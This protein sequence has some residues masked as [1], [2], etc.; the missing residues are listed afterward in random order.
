MMEDFSSLFWVKEGHLLPVFPYQVVEVDHQD[1]GLP[2]L[3]FLPQSQ[4]HHADHNHYS[5][6]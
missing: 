1:F 5:L 2:L 4:V 6:S 3:D